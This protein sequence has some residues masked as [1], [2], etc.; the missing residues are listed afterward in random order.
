MKLKQFIQILSQEDPELEVI[1]QSD[2]E[3]NGYSPF[4]SYWI[5]AYR[6]ITTWYGEAGY[7]TLTDELIE[8]GFSEEELITNGTKAIFLGPVA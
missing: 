2:S 8:D 3:G 6:S 4:S 7:D 1:M 5:G